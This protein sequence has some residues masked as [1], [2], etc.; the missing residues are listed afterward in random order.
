MIQPAEYAAYILS[1]GSCQNEANKRMQVT[2]LPPASVMQILPYF[3]FY[4]QDTETDP[5]EC[6]LLSQSPNSTSLT[7]YHLLP[8]MHR[9]PFQLLTDLGCRQR[10]SLALT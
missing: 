9:R 1:E 3:L 6:A 7:K 2:P 10:Q 5:Q 8:S 4:M